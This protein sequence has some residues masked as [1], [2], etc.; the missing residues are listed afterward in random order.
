MP[1]G[2]LGVELAAGDDAE[3]VLREQ[4]VE[5]RVGRVEHELRASVSSTTLLDWKSMICDS[6]PPADS[7]AFGSATR[8]MLE[9]GVL[10]GDRL[11]VVEGDALAHRDRPGHG[12]GGGL[13]RLGERGLELVVVVPEQQRLVEVAAPR[14]VGRL[15]RLVRVEGVLAAA[16]GGAVDEDA[17]G[18]LRPAPPPPPPPSSPHAARKLLPATAARR[19]RST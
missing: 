16:A 18:A 15:D 2:L 10:G 11:A 19:G 8:W 6:W 14:D 3:R 12:V 9:P 7:G 17:A 5:D 13:D 1:T 4:R